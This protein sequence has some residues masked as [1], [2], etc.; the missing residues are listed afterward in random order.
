ML[1]TV[2]LHMS[3][4]IIMG[5]SSVASTTTFV[6]DQRGCSIPLSLSRALYRS[7]RED[8]LVILPFSAVEGPLR[9][10][11]SD[12]VGH[13]VQLVLIVVSIPSISQ[14]EIVN[15]TISDGPFK[16]VLES[17]TLF[18]GVPIIP[19][20][21]TIPAFVPLV[22]PAEGGGGKLK[23]LL[24]LMAFK[25]VS[26]GCLVEAKSCVVYSHGLTLDMLLPLVVRFSLLLR[27]PI[28]SGKK[29][30]S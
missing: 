24:L 10:S 3:V 14:K 30:H 1:M 26:C 19:M 11:A 7:D 4:N 18:G 25:N 28:E 20:E 8:P 2:L 22:V 17:L 12:G 27:R 13:V 21:V 9:G 15:L 23:I 29:G 6:F 16:L 5:S